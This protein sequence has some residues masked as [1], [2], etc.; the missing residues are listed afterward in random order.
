MRYIVTS[1]KDTDEAEAVDITP[2]RVMT[3]RHKVKGV[4][5][6]NAVDVGT[7]ILEVDAVLPV[8]R[9]AENARRPDISHACADRKCNMKFHLRLAQLLHSSV[10]TRLPQI[11]YN[12]GL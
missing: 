5:L 4:Q 8:D 9:P 6:R 3:R 7:V 10:W 11:I 12:H 1:F 2:D